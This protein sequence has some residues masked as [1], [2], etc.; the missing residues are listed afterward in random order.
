M[1]QKKTPKLDAPA[2]PIEDS[3]EA[4]VKLK[5]SKKPLIAMVAVA[6]VGAAAVTAFLPSKKARPAAPSAN[7]PGIPSEGGY[8]EGNTVAAP[9][10]Q[11]VPADGPLPETA[12]GDTESEIAAAVQADG[13]LYD[14]P[15]APGLPGDP[16]DPAR[17]TTPAENQPNSNQATIES[18]PA[19]ISTADPVVAPVVAPVTP[20]QLASSKAVPPPSATAL[21]PLAAAVDPAVVALIES[22]TSALRTDLAE[23]LSR[24]SA[25]QVD[26]AV[27]NI[28]KARLDGFEQRLTALETGKTRGPTVA[29]IEKAASGAAGISDV[30][31]ATPGQSDKPRRAEARPARAPGPVAVSQTAQPSSPL[32]GSLRDIYSVELGGLP[33]DTRAS[34]RFVGE[35][36]VPKISTEAGGRI[37]RMQ[38]DRA[39][40]LVSPPLVPAGLVNRVWITKRGEE[41]GRSVRFATSV[42]V[43]PNVTVKMDQDGR[44]GTI[45]VTFK[46]GSGSTPGIVAVDNSTPDLPLSRAW[47]VQGVTATRA[48]LRSVVTRE[49]QVVTIGTPVA[50]D[51]SGTVT[52]LDP[53]GAVYTSQVRIGTQAVLDASTSTAFAV[54]P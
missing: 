39:R 21:D 40:F 29:S 5:T 19:T 4:P 37:L 33:G 30:A 8:T 25:R 35:K 1:F 20:E 14:P 2:T 22:R 45:N 13:G 10:S 12:T 42:G 41:P 49:M 47:V 38:I 50:D 6:F 36:P 18:A 11:P 44:H 32:E 24:E 17:N 52:R 9:A 46:R 43:T 54:V 15:P 48:I 23:A 7:S 16:L 28:L 26:V 53:G 3:A 27:N 31:S 34:F 51:Q